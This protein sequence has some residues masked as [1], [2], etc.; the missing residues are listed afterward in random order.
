MAAP[1]V[2]TDPDSSNNTA[3]LTT[4]VVPATKAVGVD[5]GI[6]K[7]GP[8]G[9][10]VGDRYSYGIEVTNLS[11]GLEATNVVIEDTLPQGIEFQ[12]V[13]PLEGP[14]PVCSRSSNIVSCTLQK[15]SHDSL[16]R[17]AIMVYL[18]RRPVEATNTV[19]VRATEA[20]VNPSNNRTEYRTAV[21]GF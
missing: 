13:F 14:V 10:R 4:L 18:A 3:S 20:D 2:Q 6:I 12:Y 11:A 15:L 1:V 5:L 7:R 8:V 19:E 16:V 21:T 17:F 9:V